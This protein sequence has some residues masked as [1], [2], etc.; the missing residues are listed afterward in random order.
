LVAGSLWGP[1]AAQSLGHGVDLIA[2]V[3]QHGYAL[4]AVILFTA[5]LGL[6]L[7]MA[8][9]L[10]A[11]GAASHHG[12]QPGLVLAVA[13]SAAMAGDLLL[14]LGGKHT[15]WWLLT[16]IC[17]VSINPEQCIFSSADS[18]YRR[19]PQTLLFAKFIPGLGTVAAP[20]AG[21]LN[22]RLPRFLR[23]M[24]VGELFYCG[25]WLT[26]GYV[27]FQFVR[28]VAAWIESVGH[29][30]L[31]VLF[32]LAAGYGVTILYFVL[33]SRRYRQIEKISAARL[34]ERIED[35][36]NDRLVV[37]ADVRSHNYY[38]P[39]MHRIKNSIRVEPNRLQE[40]LEALKEFM[41]PDCEIYLYCSCI[42]DT[43]SVRVA[44]AMKQA[45]LRTTVIEGGM[46]AW[47]RAG[48]ELEPVPEAD[49]R[50]LPR[51]D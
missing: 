16:G 14:Y 27:F 22:M 40:E 51:F 20:L 30:V 6:P 35:S 46:K 41:A 13:W 23:L 9:T 8:I 24:A 3:A 47:A 29:A 44:H 19:G 4:T 31:L 11:A 37:I 49:L 36:D 26:V 7:P 38:D 34:Q 28:E 15:G 42:R 5:A 50:R 21:S 1:F 33:R 32:L 17:W 25:T 45:N 10:L 2:I 43:T 48:G 18:F 12:L 39:G